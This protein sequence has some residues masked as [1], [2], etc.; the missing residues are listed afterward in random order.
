[1]CEKM[2]DSLKIFGNGSFLKLWAGQGIS[3]FGDMIT[4]LAIPMIVYN[5]TGS[6]SALSLSVL[7][8]VIPVILI[9]PFAGALVDRLNRKNILI[10]SDL[11]RASL[12]M[13]LLLTPDQYLLKMI[14]IVVFL[15]SLIGIFFGPALNSTIPSIIKKDDLMAANSVFGVSANIL[16]FVSPFAGGALIAFFGARS[17][18]MIDMISFIVSAIAIYF[19]NIPKHPE[20]ARKIITPALLLKDIAEGMRFIV[21]SKT[22]TVIM[23]TTLITQF[24]QGFISPLWLPYV[25]EGLKRPAT[26]FGL[27]VSMQGFGSIVGTVLLLLLGVRKSKSYKPYYALFT[28]MTGVTIFMQITTLNFNIFIIWGTLVGVFI[29]GMGVTT[30]TIIQH[31]AKNEV[32]GRV[33]STQNIISQGFMAAAVAIAGLMGDQLTTRILFIMACSIWLVGCV[34]GS[35]LMLIN[36]EKVTDEEPVEQAV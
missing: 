6:K 3:I 23:I 26:D 11:I 12:T 18:L 36:K 30:Q 7:I 25:V 8:R 28:L 33:S 22:L 13:V 9:G 10:G 2:K 29:S 4:F 20:H 19:I 31:I 34:I 5:L 1:M 27:L 32:L 15:K 17:V 14:Y 35:G 16:T 21:R 24:G